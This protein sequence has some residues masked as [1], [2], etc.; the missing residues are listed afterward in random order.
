MSIMK[1]LRMIVTETFKIGT[2]GDVQGGGIDHSVRRRCTA[3]GADKT[4]MGSDTD[5]QHRYGPPQGFIVPTQ[6]WCGGTTE[7]Q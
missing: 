6:Q 7:R 1:G 3:R 5:A 4:L 2:G